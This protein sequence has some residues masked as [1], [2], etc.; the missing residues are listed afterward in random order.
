MLPHMK[1]ARDLIGTREVKGPE[2][3][4]VIMEMYRSVGHDW[5]EHDEVAWCAAFVGHCIEKVGLKS[6]RKLTARSYLNYGYDIDLNDARDGDIVIFSR[7]NSTWQG[8]VGFYTGHTKNG[9]KVLGGNQGDRVS[10]ATYPKSKL[11]GVRR[12]GGVQVATEPDVVEVQQRLRDLGYFEVGE[13][14]GQFGPRTRAAIL[15]FKADNGLE[16]IAEIDTS[17]IVALES[18][19][20]RKVSEKRSNGKPKSSRIVNGADAQIAGGVAGT[21]VVVGESVKTGVEK[22]EE[23]KSIIERGLDMVGL[24]ETLAP[25]IPFAA[26]AIFIAVI[27]FGWKIRKARI[28]DYQ[29]GKTP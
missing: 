7:G 6:T 2:D 15:A 14:D 5:V 10:I 29:A 28:E 23:A 11:L 12:V 22:T 9:I 26:A 1:V 18:A 25:F 13:V 20:P 19:R 3:S 24:G 27:F 8:H 16:L 17:L 21:A 4:P